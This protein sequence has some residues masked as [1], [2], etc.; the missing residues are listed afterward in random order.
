M[1]KIM[2]ILSVAFCLIFICTSSSFAFFFKSYGQ[3]VYVGT[4]FLTWSS[5]GVNYYSW[6]RIVIRN[7][8]PDTPIRVKRVNFYG[9]NIPH[10]PT[11]PLLPVKEF[12]SED[13]N[14][15]PWTSIAY[16]AN[17]GT[18]GVPPYSPNNDR[19]F[20]IVEWEADERIIPPSIGA[21]IYISKVSLNDI[22]DT[23]F[24]K[25]LVIERK[26]R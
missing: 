8:D 11:K 10:P 22:I 5:D 9:Q 15:A 20:F 16:K 3:T 1:K 12:L 23:K 18:L 26:F 25:G 13:V 2:L 14:I 17:Q 7:V 24:I 21:L 4:G 19:P 6:S